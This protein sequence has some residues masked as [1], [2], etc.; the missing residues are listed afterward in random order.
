MNIF[1]NKAKYLIFPM[2][3]SKC[4]QKWPFR[5]QNQRNENKISEMRTNECMSDK[6]SSRDIFAYYFRF[7]PYA[8]ALYLAFICIPQLFYSLQNLSVGWYLVYGLL[9]FYNEC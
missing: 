8:Q 1:E 4:K 5:E 6:E 7:I 2:P 9:L 3:A